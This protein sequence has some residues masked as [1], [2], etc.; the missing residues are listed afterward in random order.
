MIEVTAADHDRI[1]AY[2]SHLPQLISTALAATVAIQ[3]D[4]AGNQMF[5]PGLLDMT[6]L[7]LSPPE[8]WTSI[9]ATNK[10][11]ILAALEAYTATLADLK[12]AVTDDDLTALFQTST[13]FSR[14][15]RNL[16]FVTGK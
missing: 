16:C 1:L 9:V 11:E 2:T 3:K 4:V 6:R 10:A 8:L 15:I 5:G 14:R 7:A 13:E 12:R